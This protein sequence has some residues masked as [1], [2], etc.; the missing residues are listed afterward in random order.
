MKQADRADPFFLSPLYFSAIYLLS[1]WLFPK[2]YFNIRSYMR[3]TQGLEVRRRQSF[4]NVN[5]I[6][7][8]GPKR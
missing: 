5:P 7:K 6:R 3:S 1:E 8:G 4:E 2:N